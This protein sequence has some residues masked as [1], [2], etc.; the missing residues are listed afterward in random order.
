VV[1]STKPM[2]TSHTAPRP[3]ESAAGDRESAVKKQPQIIFRDAAAI[4][5]ARH[6]PRGVELLR[7]LGHLIR[8]DRALSQK[9]RAGRRAG[10]QA[11]G[12]RGA[13]RERCRT[14]ARRAALLCELAASKCDPSLRTAAERERS[15]VRVASRRRCGAFALPSP[16]GGTRPQLEIQLGAAVCDA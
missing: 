1:A 15:G 10:A 8:R 4:A 5:A 13:A 3:R 6:A 16:V 9:K 12:H 11:W 14:W 2:A 7:R